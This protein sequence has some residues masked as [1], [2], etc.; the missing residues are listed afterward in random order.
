M[1]QNSDLIVQTRNLT[2]RFGK[3]TAVDNLNIE[4]YPG[5][6]FGFL[7]PNGS[8]KSTTIG[9]M[10]GFVVP[11]SGQARV[12]GKNV[13]HH[14]PEILKRIGAL[15]ESSGFYPYLSGKDNLSYIAHITGGITKKRVDEVLEL[16]ELKGR[17]ND[18]FSN[19][20]MGMKQ[21]LGIASALLSDPEFVVLDEPTNGLDPAGM[22]EIRE[23]II[24][25]G[26]Q[27]KTVF[28][29]SHL[30]HEIQLIASRV[31][32][33]KNGKV[34]AQGTVKELMNRGDCLQIRVTE[35]E[36][37]EALFNNLDW[38]TSVKRE[39]EKLILGIKP[40]LA[41]EVSAVL[42]RDGIY[43]TEMKTQDNTLEDLFLELTGEEAHV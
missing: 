23:L 20:S 7:G 38:I 34:I 13:K 16:V 33:I 4:V 40:E 28:V 31:A 37:A 39:D 11:T 10:L 35:P 42:A 8:G 24:S 41:A 25:L 17:A 5:E 12:F 21:R 29:N 22:K 18:P 43:L 3:I 6:V 36:K 26:E 14:L 32:I 2:K 30:L 1:Q 9:M 15:T 27:G 19:Y